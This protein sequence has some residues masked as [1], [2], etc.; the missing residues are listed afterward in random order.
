M[1]TVTLKSD[2]GPEADAA[3]DEACA[4]FPD[5][6]GLRNYEGTF[7]VNRRNSYVSRGRL[8]IYTDM[9]R[10]GKW[11]D[12]CKGTVDELNGQI[13]RHKVCSICLK[14]SAVAGHSGKCVSCWTEGAINS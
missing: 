5:T 13:V 2:F 1:K 12:F 8:M 14:S 11:C 7:R 10:D 6:F 3:L 4:Q 9:L